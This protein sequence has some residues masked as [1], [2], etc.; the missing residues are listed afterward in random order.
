[1]ILKTLLVVNYYFWSN[2]PY[3]IRLYILYQCVCNT[4][5]IAFDFFF[6]IYITNITTASCV[7][8]FSKYYLLFFICAIS[9][10]Y[11]QIN[12]CLLWWSSQSAGTDFHTQVSYQQGWVW[13]WWLWWNLRKTFCNL[14]LLMVVKY[15]FTSSD[16][17]SLGNQL[18]R[19]PSRLDMLQGR[20]EIWFYGLRG[21]IL[22]QINPESFPSS[23]LGG[24]QSIP[25]FFTRNTLP[26][27]VS[28]FST[29]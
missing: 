18:S 24:G 27:A 28:S 15:R 9:P 2:W 16:G 14:L 26:C 29:A 3:M 4:R 20:S 8:I 12:M 21:K 5:S 6:Q 10:S 19:L 7:I 25:S 17:V 13:I 1:M 23:W 11:D 22:I